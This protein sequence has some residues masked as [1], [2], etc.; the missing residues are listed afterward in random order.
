MKDRNVV[1]GVKLIYILRDPISRVVVHVHHNLL[2]RDEAADAWKNCAK[3]RI[4]ILWP[5]GCG[6]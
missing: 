1:P 2:K 3:P 5:A 6:L 4:T